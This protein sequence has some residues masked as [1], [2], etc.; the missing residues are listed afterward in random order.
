MDIIPYLLGVG[1]TIA[2]LYWVVVNIRRPAGTP[3]VGL[4]RYRETLDAPAKAGSNAKL[5]QDRAPP[6]HPSQAPPPIGADLPRRAV[7]DALSEAGR[8]LGG[9]GASLRPPRT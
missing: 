5:P 2:A 7:E 3:T 9:T 4:F 8:A 1:M 6:D